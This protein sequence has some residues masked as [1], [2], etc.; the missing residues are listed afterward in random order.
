MQQIRT[1]RGL[2]MYNTDSEVCLYKNI[3]KLRKQNRW[4]QEELARK[5]GYTDR[6]SI[7]KIESGSV[8]LTLSKIEEFARIFGMRPEDLTGWNS[9][10]NSY[11]QTI[12]VGRAIEFYEKYK[13]AIPQIQNAVNLILENSRNN[14]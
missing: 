1:D 5:A 12:E 11:I 7:A 8:D 2:T 4:T 3:K 6:S 14:S 13:N 9:T 10:N